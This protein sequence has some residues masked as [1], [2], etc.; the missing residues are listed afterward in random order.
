MKLQSLS[1]NFG[2][3]RPLSVYPTKSL[4]ITKMDK[5]DIL[6]HLQYPPTLKRLDLSNNSIEDLSLII[7]ALPLGL[8]F[9]SFEHNP[10]SWST[11]LPNFAK[12][13]QLNYLRLM[14]THIG[15]HFSRFQFPD[16]LEILSLE[17]NQIE[18]IDHVKFPKNLVNLGIGS[19]KIKVVYKPRFPPTIQTI[20]FTENN[21]S[22][23]DLSTNHIGQPLQ[24]TT[25]YLNYNR[26]T[27]L[28]NVK[29]P[30]NLIILNFDNC[31]IETLLDTEFGKTIEELSLVDVNKGVEEYHI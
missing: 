9:I 4:T 18:S 7:P 14:N 22:K 15:K 29:L 20:H 31:C 25:L 13:A 1:L 21:I 27:S 16:S 26:I 10:I 12:F 30:S 19:N 3:D 17:V 24:I 2:L 28:K 8:E 23:V 5:P 11:Y 6:A